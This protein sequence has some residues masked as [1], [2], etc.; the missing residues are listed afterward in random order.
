MMENQIALRNSQ[1][2]KYK[3]TNS[4][5]TTRNSQNIIPP[6]FGPVKDEF[7]RIYLELEA[8]DFV[9]RFINLRFNQSSNVRECK[10][11]VL[12]LPNILTFS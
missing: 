4:Q 6:E 9:K 2:A 10:I 11:I 7:R 8:F 5:L 3:K 1:L 12:S